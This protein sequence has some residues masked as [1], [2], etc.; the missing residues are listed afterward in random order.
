MKNSLTVLLL[1]LLACS[2]ASAGPDQ[3]RVVISCSA[4]GADCVKKPAQPRQ[5]EK[6]VLPPDTPGDA[7]MGMMAAPMMMA[8]P[9]LAAAAMPPAPSTPASLSASELSPHVAVIP[10][11]AHAACAKRKHG[12]KMTVKLGPNETLAGSCERDKGKMR[13]R[14]R[15]AG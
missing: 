9:S 12:S 7:R 15:H 13:F 6:P 5:S 4:G 3:A 10:N 1:A 8:P 11:A 2:G 14:A